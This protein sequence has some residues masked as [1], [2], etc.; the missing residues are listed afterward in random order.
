ML[1]MSLK[2]NIHQNKNGSYIVEASITLPLLIISVCSLVLIIKI[3]ATCE[4]ITFITS[5]SLL[6]T[7]FGYNIGFNEKSLCKDVE[8]ISKNILDFR[9]TKY[10]YLYDDKEMMDLIALDAKADFNVTNA[11][12]INGNISFSEKILC[13]GF[14]GTS[15]NKSS[16]NK[17]EF[18]KLKQAATIYIFPKYGERYHIRDC[19]YIEKSEIEN[20]YIVKMDREDALRKGYTPCIVCKGAANE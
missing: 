20:G 6:D 1:L 12:G 3:I 2:K 9:V 10:R 18:N 7:I 13:R 16:L 11:I 14:T 4:A 5:S 8:E 17:E 19:R 15:Q